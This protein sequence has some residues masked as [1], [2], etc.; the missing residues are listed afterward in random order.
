MS[1]NLGLGSLISGSMPQREQGTQDSLSFLSSLVKAPSGDSG[2][3]MVD[4]AFQHAFDSRVH[5]AISGP[6]FQQGGTARQGFAEGEAAASAQRDLVT[7]AQG[8]ANSLLTNNLGTAAIAPNYETR[9]TN[10]NGQQSGSQGQY[11]LTCCFI[12]MEATNGP[13]EP[14]VRRARDYF[15]TRYPSAAC[16]YMRLAQ[17]L[18]PAMR[19]SRAVKWL[20]NALMVRPMTVAGRYV[21]EGERSLRSCLSRI[22]AIA[23]M[24]TFRMIG[25]KE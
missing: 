14:T 16:G 18:V 17:W 24:L 6:T 5:Q 15:Y 4:D 9:T 19:T 10:T 1:D 23:W 7:Q 22:P 2:S 25:R 13:L 21:F 8:A 3:P 11:G 12:F 20:V